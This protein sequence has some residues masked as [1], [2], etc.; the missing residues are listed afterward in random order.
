[1]FQLYKVLSLS[2]SLLLFLRE[3]I[4]LDFNACNR[5]AAQRGFEVL[6]L[7]AKHE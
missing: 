6:C 2:V 1:M 7:E 5:L 4:I 3:G